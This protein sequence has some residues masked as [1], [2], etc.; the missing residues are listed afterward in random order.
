[1]QSGHY[2]YTPTYL[3]CR[4]CGTLITWPRWARVEHLHYEPLCWSCY[5]VLDASFTPEGAIRR[6]RAIVRSAVAR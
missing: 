6:A 2:T 1:M 4:H 5:A 3:E